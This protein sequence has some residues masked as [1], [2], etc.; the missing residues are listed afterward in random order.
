MFFVVL[1]NSCIFAG[2]IGDT[3]TSS[4]LALQKEHKKD[5]VTVPY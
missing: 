3:V 2:E 1:N 4:I 5:L